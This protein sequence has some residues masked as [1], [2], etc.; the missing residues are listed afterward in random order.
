M[1]IALDALGET[2]RAQAASAGIDLALMH[3]ITSLATGSL[4][5]LPHNGAVVTLLGICGLGHREAYGP[6]FAVAVAITLL[7]LIVSIALGTAF[8][9]F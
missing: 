1:S 5:A 6:T 3:R 9:A 7:A 4:D 2:Y 8:G